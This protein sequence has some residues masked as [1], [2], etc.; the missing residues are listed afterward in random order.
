MALP[1]SIKTNFPCTLIHQA[2]TPS[3]KDCEYFYMKTVDGNEH[4]FC[5]NLDLSTK[6]NVKNGSWSKDNLPPCYL[7][8][9]YTKKP[10]KGEKS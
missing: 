1:G 6:K 8:E 10:L 4:E 2:L 3:P 7:C 9:K 5:G